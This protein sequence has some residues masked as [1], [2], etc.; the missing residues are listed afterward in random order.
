MFQGTLTGNLLGFLY[1]TVFLCGGVF[2]TRRLFPALSPLTRL[3]LGITAGIA[4][5][6]WLP[7]LCSFLLGFT[8][9]S[10]L[11]ALV[12]LGALCAAAFFLAKKNAKKKS[13]KPVSPVSWKK[14]DWRALW[15]ILPMT[16]FF[17]V[18]ETNHILYPA[19]DGGLIFG[20]STYWDA[21]IH[22][23]FIT[24]PV[25]Q[26]TMPFVYNILPT[27]QVSYP[28]LCDTVSASVYLWGSSLRFAY[29]L[30]TVA[31][32][33]SVF[34]GGF[35]FF[36]L[37]LSTFAKAALAW[38]LFFFNGGF[39][40]FYFLDG[41]KN[42][43]SN[44]TR[45]FTALY[46]TPTN[47]NDKMIRWVNTVCDMMIPQRASLFGWM[48]LFAVLYLLYRAVF[49]KEKR[50]FLYAGILAGLTPLI[51]T[52]NFLAM[53]LIA[54]VW[55]LSRLAV[56]VDLKAHLARAVVW[57]IA[58]LTVLA[59]VLVFFQTKKNYDTAGLAAL[60]A[61]GIPIG[62]LFI[63]LLAWALARG[64]FKELLTTWGL[65]LGVVL[66]LALPQLFLFT[67]RQSGGG[68]FLRPHFNWVNGQDNYIWFN[69]KNIGIPALLILPAVLSASKRQKSILA[70][71]GVVWL[72][73]ET[74]AFQPNTYDNNKLLYPVFILMCGGVAD[75]M[76]LIWER[77]KA[78]RGMK[79]LACFV[80]L[81]CVVSGALSMG[82][83]AVSNEYEIF[84]APQV[85]LA[86]WV[87]NNVEPDAML[88]TNDRYNNT[89]TGMTGRN[90]VCGS[91][92]FL[93]THG[94]TKEFTRLQRDIGAIYAN[95]DAARD[96]IARYGVDYI[97]VGPDEYASYEVNLTAL[98]AV[99]ECV[100]DTDGVAVWRV[101]ER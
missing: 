88:L 95:A 19:A 22:L 72:I 15:F 61:G 78:I 101:N 18:V 81:I 45:M 9:L 71:I 20:Q 53:G 28:F 1:F 56:M 40:V 43:P 46:E 23:S 82:R 8:V 30:P 64:H 49:M 62:A 21:N 39:G 26:K 69:I 55:M 47:L 34:C 92:S 59:F 35:L 100:Y 84:S 94:L 83:E 50:F 10:H 38:T 89:V 5:L 75:F 36:R 29:I 37:W 3:W 87:E 73:A 51:S 86:W 52:H 57:G 24:T 31:A 93:S 25:V 48:M 91:H 11:I 98:A 68:G 99:A 41:L 65:F 16:V 67:F 13:K 32:A 85:K 12:P 14:E 33:F 74:F 27:H 42:D 60:L 63:G 77:L 76:L 7:V 66:V 96:L 4:L 2:L 44:F 70:P 6:M 97:I 90:I 79:I 80:L 17:T 54:A 58:A